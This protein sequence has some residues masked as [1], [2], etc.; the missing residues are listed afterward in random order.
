[1]NLRL[2]GQGAEGDEGMPRGNLF[3]NVEVETDLYF[4]RDGADI[5]VESPISITQ[6]ILGGTVDVKTLTG[7]VELTVPK[8]AQMDTKLLMRGKG[9]QKLNGRKRKGDQVVHLK[10]ELP[11]SITERQEELLREFEK[12]SNEEKK[13]FGEK[14]KKGAGDFLD[15]LF[16]GK[17]GKDGE[18]KS[19]KGSDDEKSSDDKKT[20]A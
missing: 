16:G 6:A 2:A 17:D 18:K 19:K 4:V 13:G 1:M 11:K 10:I 5:H 15:G 12:I 20:S 3:V 9:V 14:V 7:E 8:G